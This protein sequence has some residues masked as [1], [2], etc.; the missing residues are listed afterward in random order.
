M[1]RLG[2]RKTDGGRIVSAVIITTLATLSGESTLQ[3]AR[4]YTQQFVDAFSWST[5]PAL[6]SP[7]LMIQQFQQ[8]MEANLLIGFLL[9]LGPVLAGVVSSLDL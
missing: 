8:S 2:S 4:P 7:V 3:Q 6:E 1:M 9:M 5:H